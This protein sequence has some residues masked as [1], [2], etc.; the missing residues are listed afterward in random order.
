MVHRK[1]NG[2]EKMRAMWAWGFLFGYVSGR[3][4]A[5]EGTVDIHVNS[6]MAITKI[7][8]KDKE[9]SESRIDKLF[10]DLDIVFNEAIGATPL[11]P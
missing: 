7:L 4:Q 8:Q 3:E 11:C 2:G 9:M 10:A 6:L 5:M 1:L